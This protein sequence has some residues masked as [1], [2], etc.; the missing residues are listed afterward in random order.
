MSELNSTPDHFMVEIEKIKV[1][2]LEYEINRDALYQNAD[3]AVS[4]AKMQ[5]L[6]EIDRKISFKSD[7]LEQ[8]SVEIHRKQERNRLLE[9]EYEQLT[10][11]EKQSLDARRIKSES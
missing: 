9:L 8:Q 10:Q 3:V 2:T 11:K 5:F 1:K 4:V 6:N 7:D